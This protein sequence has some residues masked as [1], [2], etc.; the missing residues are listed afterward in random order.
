MALLEFYVEECSHCHAMASL[1]ERLNEEEKLAVEKYEV[2]HNKENA[3]K[4]AE[5]DKGLC[6]GVP[7]FYNTESKGFICGEASYNDLKAWANGDKK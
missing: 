3:E 1:V 4:A 6:G 5:Y 7:F 2:W